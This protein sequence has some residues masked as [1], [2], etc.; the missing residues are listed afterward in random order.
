MDLGVPLKVRSSVG[1]QQLGQGR[2]LVILFKVMR[3]GPF[4]DF[5]KSFIVFLSEIDFYFSVQFTVRS[6][7]LT[8]SVVNFD[9]F[10]RDL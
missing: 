1:A 3:F 9:V 6:L 5:G 10:L 8:Q 7:D 2:H 4:K